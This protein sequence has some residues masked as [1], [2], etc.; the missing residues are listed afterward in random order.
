MGL[1]LC[2]QYG[3]QQSVSQLERVIQSQCGIT[4]SEI[5]HNTALYSMMLLYEVNNNVK[6]S[7]GKFSFVHWIELVD[8]MVMKNC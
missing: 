1:V 6:C 4:T 2:Q 5:K 3:S 8:F 7:F